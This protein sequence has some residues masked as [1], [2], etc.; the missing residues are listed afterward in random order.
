MRPRAEHDREQAK[1]PDWISSYLVP[2]IGSLVVS[3]VMLILIQFLSTRGWMATKLPDALAIIGTFLAIFG[4]WQTAVG[5]KTLDNMQ[6]AERRL[7]AQVTNLEDATRRNLVGFA[8]IFARALWMLEGAED[9]L[10]YV[11]FVFGLGSPHIC[12][13]EILAD[14][15]RK[16]DAL[17]L[18]HRIYGDAVRRFQQLLIEKAQALS[19]FT[20]LTLSAK[21]LEGLF[22]ERLTMAEPYKTQLNAKGILAEELKLRDSFRDIKRL[23]QLRGV[24]PEKLVTPQIERLPLQLMITRVKHGAQ[25]ERKW[26]C[27]V[28]LIGTENVG[29]TPVGYYT[30]LGHMVEMYR[31]LAMGLI[32]SVRFGPEEA[33]QQAVKQVASV[34]QADPKLRSLQEGAANQITPR[35]TDSKPAG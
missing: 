13:P 34:A 15:A 6:A 31:N 25:D 12:N 18:S 10:V 9:E 16:A 3:A 14:Y 4:L 5:G 30:E 1:R 7:T 2:L 27:L 21:S 11:N 28:F 33:V 24:D 35:G 22:F 26:G 32:E 20:T 17:Q 8:D 23:R 19:A 29:G